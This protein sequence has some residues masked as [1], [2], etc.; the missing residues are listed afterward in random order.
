MKNKVFK[1]ID[2]RVSALLVCDVIIAAKHAAN[3]PSC[4]GSS[5]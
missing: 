4:M 3:S 5:D 1:L 2:L